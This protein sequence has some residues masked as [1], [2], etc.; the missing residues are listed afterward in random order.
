MKKGKSADTALLSALIGEQAPRRRKPLTAAI[1]MPI[2]AAWILVIALLIF[3]FVILA[4][5]AADYE[6][7]K[8]A[9]FPYLQT[10]KQKPNVVVYESFDSINYT[11]R[12]IDIDAVKKLYGLGSVIV[13]EVSEEYIF[14]K[15]QPIRATYTG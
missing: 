12:S 7:R 8:E 4:V 6:R 3:P 15:L 14:L 5:S 10:L 13:I 9:A 11:D 2:V 1:V